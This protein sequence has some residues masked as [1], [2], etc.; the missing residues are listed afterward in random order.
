MIKRSSCHK[1]RF[2]LLFGKTQQGGIP[3]LSATAEYALR[4]VVH[5][6]REGD[7]AALQ[8]QELADATGVPQS[9]MRKVLHELVRARVLSSTR[10]K[11][12]GFTLAVVPKRLTLLAIVSRFDELSPSR[13]CLLGRAECSDR[14]PCPVHDRWKAAAE[15]VAAFFRETTLADVLEDPPRRRAATRRKPGKRSGA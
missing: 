11:G 2:A 14:D 6:A 8:A 4:A 7:T 10:G 5:L 1:D 3:I 9:Y 13:R 15:E 12:G